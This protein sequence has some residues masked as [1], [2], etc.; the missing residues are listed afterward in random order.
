MHAVDLDLAIANIWRIP[1]PDGQGVCIEESVK[2]QEAE[3]TPD[4][5]RGRGR[6]T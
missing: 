1:M 2:K 3:E 6:R 5:W 4:A